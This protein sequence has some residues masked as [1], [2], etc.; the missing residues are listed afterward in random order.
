VFVVWF[1][2][3]TRRGAGPHI[4][5]L[6]GRS[7][8]PSRCGAVRTMNR[9]IWLGNLS[10]SSDLF[11]TSNSQPVSVA[12]RP[13][14]PATSVTWTSLPH[15]DLHFGK[16]IRT[17]GIDRRQ[18]KSRVD[19]DRMASGWLRKIMCLSPCCKS[20]D[21]G[22]RDCTSANKSCLWSDLSVVLLNRTLLN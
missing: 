16:P 4:G 20:V 22:R 21:V 2:G 15:I 5:A 18:G 8:F 11:R 6:A 12:S 9:F 7:S 13:R 19:E 10:S 14:T 1:G 17:G 3:Y